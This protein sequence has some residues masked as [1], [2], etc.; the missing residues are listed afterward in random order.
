MVHVLYI[1]THTHL[2]YPPYSPPH[3]RMCKQ[4]AKLLLGHAY[5]PQLY[6]FV[7]APSG[8]DA[9]IVLAPIGSEDFVLV[10]PHCEGGY[11]LPQVPNLECAVTAGG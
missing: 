11:R 10:G 6:C 1:H 3:I 9:I 5:I 4:R 8:N 2:V 7:G